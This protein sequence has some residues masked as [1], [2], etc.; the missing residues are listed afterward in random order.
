MKLFCICTVS[1]HPSLPT[2]GRRP[3]PS[4]VVTSTSVRPSCPF[5]FLYQRLAFLRIQQAET[6]SSGLSPSLW[7][8]DVFLIL[9]S[10]LLYEHKHSTRLRPP[11]ANP[12]SLMLL[13]SPQCKKPVHTR[14]QPAAT[15]CG[16][17]DDPRA[18]AALRPQ[19]GYFS[20][21]CEE[22]PDRGELR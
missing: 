10:L 20:L 5:L 2:C 14:R 8:P 1:P 21:H 3:V 4:C 11:M 7:Y 19:I 13:R 9:N 22:I 18:V 6:L 12:G 16:P 17:P 15:C